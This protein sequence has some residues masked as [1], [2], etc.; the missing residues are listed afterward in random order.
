MC[1]KMQSLVL[2]LA[3][4]QTINA[5]KYLFV[6]PIPGKSHAILGDAMVELL[7]AAGHEVNFYINLK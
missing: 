5:Y 6:S 1:K 7:V 4:F 2:I 3:T